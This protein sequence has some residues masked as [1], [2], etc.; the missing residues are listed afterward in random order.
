MHAFKSDNE[1]QHVTFCTSLTLLIVG[2]DGQQAAVSYFQPT[3]EELQP[4]LSQIN[5]SAGDVTSGNIEAASSGDG[6]QTVMSYDTLT[7][8]SLGRSLLNQSVQGSQS[9]NTLHVDFHVN[10]PETVTQ[11]TTQIEAS[12]GNSAQSS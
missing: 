9:E 1:V 10:Q 3:H 7:A 11:L 4:Q 6:T 8:V 5:T 2:F 12:T